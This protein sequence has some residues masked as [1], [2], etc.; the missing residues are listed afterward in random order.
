MTV[1]AQ[2]TPHPLE[3]FVG[4]WSG[5]GQGSYPTI[6]SFGYHEEITIAT[7][8]GKPFLAYTQRTRAEDDG[9]PLHA[10]SGYWRCSPA[11]TPGDPLGVELVLAHPTGIVEVLEG[12]GSTGDGPR[13]VELRSTTVAGSGTAKRV[14]ATARRFEIGGDGDELRYTVAMA[15]VGQPLTH[16][17]AA[18]LRR[19]R[20]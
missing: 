18:T 2:P 12:T 4:T 19:V 16:H 1:P 3:A 14:D 20:A 15:A 10:E 17:L 13:V 6:A 9:R 11:A 5:T 7:V 8:P